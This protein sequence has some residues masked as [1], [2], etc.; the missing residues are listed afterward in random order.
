MYIYIY[1]INIYN[2]Q[3]K[4]IKII[5]NIVNLVNNSLIFIYCNGNYIIYLFISK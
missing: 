3:Y 4:E 5:G 2:S 1:N